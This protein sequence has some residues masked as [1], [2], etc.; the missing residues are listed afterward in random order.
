MTD[1][2][3]SYKFTIPQEGLTG[4]IFS[5]GIR[6]GLFYI[7]GSE[8][9]APFRIRGAEAGA[10]CRIRGALFHPQAQGHRSQEDFARPNKYMPSIQGAYGFL[11]TDCSRTGSF[12]SAICCIPW[13]AGQYHDTPG[14]VLG[15]ITNHCA[16]T[17]TRSY[18]TQAN[19]AK[20]L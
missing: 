2:R 8:A 4:Y 14:T 10:P 15:P 16:H 11:V 5:N 1:R 19:Q 6:G 13:A 18:K 12:T 9:R 3:T 20:R 17:N 7:R